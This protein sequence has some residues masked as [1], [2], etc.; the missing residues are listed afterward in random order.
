M[1]LSKDNLTF[2]PSLTQALPVGDLNLYRIIASFWGFDLISNNPDDALME[3]AETVCDVELL[4]NLFDGLPKDAM[5][6]LGFL[7]AKEGAFPWVQFLRKF[8][9]FREIGPGKRDREKPYEA[10]VSITEILWYRGLISKSF[11]NGENG[12][13]EFVYIPDEILQAMEIMG[14][15]HTVIE[16]EASDTKSIFIEEKTIQ[17]EEAYPGRLASEV[18]CK[19][20]KSTPTDILDD[21]CTYLA[22]LRSEAELPD[23]SIPRREIRTFLESLHIIEK[24][25]I[26]GEKA[27]GFLE[28]PR[29]DA[30][31]QL[32]ANWQTSGTFNELAMVPSFVLEGDW[33]NPILP[34]REFIFQ[35]LRL[36]PKGK[37]WNLNAFLRHIKENKPDF[38]RPTGD[39]DSWIIKRHQ[40]D[41]YLRGFQFWDEVE[42]E[43]IRYFITGPLYWLRFVELAS[44][45][46]DGPVIA[47]RINPSLPPQ[48][49]ETG[50]LTIS[51]NGRVGMP[52]TLP[53]SAR[54][55]ISRFCGLTNSTNGQF[56]YQISTNSLKKAK[57]Q[58]L[59]V[60]QLLVM[61]NKFAGQTI[62]PTFVKMLKRWDVAGSEASMA[63]V[64]V[65][66]FS[67]PATLLEFKNSKASRY[68]LQELNSTTV[69]I[70]AEAKEKIKVALMELGILA[71]D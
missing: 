39:Y 20:L 1:N 28:A 36:V 13:Q 65:L 5:D 58:G 41:V 68:I 67:K 26:D 19:Y 43:L 15:E 49:P 32:R 33:K 45:E 47:F 35:Q 2:M 34:T 30:I 10:P 46:K 52:A 18:E 37:W 48:P 71:A 4:E 61:L 31:K 3:L 16:E 21:S 60:D 50:K 12:L 11:L 23:L 62:S 54:Y 69:I 63:D 7:F 6:A 57:D 56:Q 38:Q 22:A 24:G 51:T 64:S 40:D 17:I 70:P 8:G 59:K 66:K 42:G 25:K 53:R 44:M 27:K 55:L 9:E 14:Y 29:T